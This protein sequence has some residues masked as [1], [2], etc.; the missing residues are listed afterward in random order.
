VIRGVGEADI[1]HS[2]AT[3]ASEAWPNPE[4]V[5]HRLGHT[6]VSFALNP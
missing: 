5:S 3:A 6:S 4:I 2:Y 1:R